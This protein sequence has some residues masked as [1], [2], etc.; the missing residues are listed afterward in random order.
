[1][2][3]HVSHQQPHY[4]IY[5]HMTGEVMGTPTFGTHGKF[6]R[7]HPAHASGYSS[8][9]PIMQPSSTQLPHL[10]EV[11]KPTQKH[12]CSTPYIGAY[13]VKL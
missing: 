4:S 10:S 7:S 9:M 3:A 11:R 5:G 6:T 13:G 2:H 1:M 12:F 8:G